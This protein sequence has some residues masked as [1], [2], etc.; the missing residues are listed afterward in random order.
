MGRQLRAYRKFCLLVMCW[1]SISIYLCFFAHQ[2]HH[3]ENANTEHVE[4]YSTST[5]GAVGI[6]SSSQIEL[7]TDVMMA[8]PSCLKYLKDTNITTLFTVNY[9]TDIKHC[10]KNSTFFNSEVINPA[11]TRYIIKNAHICERNAQYDKEVF[12]LLIILTAPIERMRR[13]IIRETWGKL[14]HTDILGKRVAFVFLLGVSESPWV[15]TD[16]KKENKQYKDI[17]KENFID[18]YNNLT[19]KTLMG[20]RWTVNFCKEAKFVLKIDSDMIPNLP[21]LVKHLNDYT[22][23]LEPLFEGHL[24]PNYAPIRNGQNKERKWN[25]DKS[26]YPYPLYPPYVNGPSYLI[27]S[28]LLPLI[29]TVSA[30]VK[31]F[32]FED[33]Y[34]GMIMNV[35]GVNP[36]NN[37]RYS[38]QPVEE[39]NGNMCHFSV[40]FTGLCPVWSVRA[41]K[42]VWTKWEDFNTDK[43]NILENM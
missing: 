7:D 38:V 6:A 14:T 34:M 11:R 18:S 3:M 27:S 12:L 4:L 29:L 43:C 20:L 37:G 30:H 22:Y 21:N 17:C 32:R 5:M 8:Q 35:I 23:N 15:E 1:S 10:V 42:L 36:K 40:A 13:D 31:Y 2:S 33:V 19:L 16:I 24:H 28:D 26:E 25:V 9:T 39:G 41:M